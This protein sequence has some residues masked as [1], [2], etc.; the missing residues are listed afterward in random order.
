MP[1][2]ILVAGF[3]SGSGSFTA[4]VERMKSELHRD[5]GVEEDYIKRALITAMQ[6]YRWRRFWFN[7][8]SASMTTVKDQSEYGP[9]IVLGS[10]D[11][12]P[13]NMLEIDHA[14]IFRNP[15]N[16]EST[17]TDTTWKMVREKTDR[18]RWWIDSPSANTN[19]PYY[20][21]YHHRTLLMYPIPD[22]EYRIRFDFLADL[23]IPNYRFTGG[24]WQ[25]F[26]RDGTE[27][28]DDFETPWLEHAEE[29]IRNRAK[30]D[31]FANVVYDTERA[32]LARGQ[33]RD[34][35]RNLK[36]ATHKQ[37]STG[38]VRGE[39][40]GEYGGLSRGYI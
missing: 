18:L 6:Y 16:A 28:G 7:E 27:L 8:G 22:N 37:L 34:A 38:S 19:Y 31:I 23:D 3:G 36:S 9:E 4:A 25:Y 33:E 39:F 29:L 20:F 1:Q 24:E 13:A 32:Q 35:L 14:F 12:Y 26:D 5:R 15:V 2:D 40:G 11:G 30:A 17:F 10:G 21:S